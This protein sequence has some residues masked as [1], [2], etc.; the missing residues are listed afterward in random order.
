[1]VVHAAA[2]GVG[3]IAVQLAKRFGA[4]RVIGLASSPAKRELAERLGAD[5]VV[6]SRAEDLTAAIRE[7]NGGAHVD[8]ILE[9]VGG[10]TFEQSLS[11]LAHFGRLVHF[12]QAGREGAPPVNP[13][14]LMATSRGVIGLWLMHLLRAPERLGEAMGELFDAVVAGELEVDRRRHLSARGGSPRARGHPRPRDDREA[15]P[16]AVSW[17]GYL[18]VADRSWPVLRRLMGLHATVYRAT[19]GLVGHHIPGLPTMLL[20]DHTGAKSGI[21][22]TT[23]LLYVVDGDDLVIVASKG[24]L[25]EAPGLVPQPA[26]PS[27]DHRPGGLGAAG[28]ARASGRCGRARRGCGRGWSTPTGATR[29]TRRAPTGRSRS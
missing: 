23:P 24:G 13:G 1:M 4:G 14:K 20:L 17:T 5:A 18:D 10:R 16:D 27:G 15:G 25:S 26:R 21:E 6:D 3:T 11:A 2:G 28:R 22:R 9:M 29:T 7:A 12:G 8:V 19:N